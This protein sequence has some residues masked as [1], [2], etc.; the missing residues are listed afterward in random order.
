MVFEPNAF[1]DEMGKNNEQMLLVP[2]GLSRYKLWVRVLTIS[3][4]KWKNN[5]SHYLKCFLT[6]M[7]FKTLEP[8]NI[9]LFVCYVIASY[10]LPSTSYYISYPL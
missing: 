10:S 5:D 9:C 1:E 6:P 2:F 7:P 8:L 4:L 3:A